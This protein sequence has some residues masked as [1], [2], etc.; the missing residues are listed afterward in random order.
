MKPSVTR[1]VRKQIFSGAWKS[2]VDGASDIVRMKPI[3]VQKTSERGFTLPEIVVAMFLITI[4]FVANFSALSISRM[5]MAKDKDYGLAL[6]FAMH[7]LELA[8]GL[9]F[10]ELKN[11]QPVNALYNGENGAPHI[12][13]PS[14]S[15]WYSLTNDDFLTFHP[16]LTWLV[17]RNPEMSVNL[18]TDQVGGEDH[19]K[20]LTM[21]V[22]WDPSLRGTNDLSIRL[23]LVRVKDL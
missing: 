9:P 15:G 6:D 23:D 14:S 17:S 8:R 1:V 18:T 20:T 5:Q 21:Q 10:E 16:E 13:I 12:V 22:R 19:I 7:Y 2:S 4:L 3:A 11:G